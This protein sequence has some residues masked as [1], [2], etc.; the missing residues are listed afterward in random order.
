MTNFP[1]SLPTE[2]ILLVVDKLRGKDASWRKV[3]LAG[4]NLLGYA[5]AQIPED[6]VTPL[7]DEP[8]PE[9]R[10]EAADYLEKHLATQEGAAQAGFVT[11]LVVAK[12]V[13]RFILNVI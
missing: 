2:A 12:I 11:W 10:E 5:L 7:L 9:T 4:W 1:D 3:A 8:S 13:L 6:T